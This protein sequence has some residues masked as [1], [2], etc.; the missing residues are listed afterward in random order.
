MRSA[1]R[2]ARWPALVRVVPM[3]RLNAV[4]V[5]ARSRAT[6]TTR[7]GSSPWSRGRGAQT[8]RSWHVYYLQNSH[9]NDVA[10]V[11]Q[12]AFTP[13]NVTAQPSARAT[14]AS[15]QPLRRHATACNSSGG[16]GGGSGGIG[17]G[18]RRRRR[19][20]HRRSAAAA[21]ARRQQ[22]G[23]A[24]GGRAPAARRQ[25]PANPLLGGLEP[26]GGGAGGGDTDTTMRIIPNPQNNAVLIYATPQEDD[27]VE[28][29]LRKIDILPLQVRIDAI[30]AEVTLN[31]ELQYGTQFFFKAAA[32]STASSTLSAAGSAANRRCVTAF[33]GFVLGG[34]GK[35]AHR[36]AISALQAVTTV[37]VLSSPRTAG[38]RQPAGPAAGRRAGAV[39]DAPARRAR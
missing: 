23:G 21:A 14:G 7:A 15:A 24:L 34:S 31:D 28:A 38:A 26:G 19:R 8:V 27:T 1:A 10:Y 37:H 5:V 6:S 35:A 16:S 11:L 30:I 22:P 17:G 39:P 20:R 29:M 32:A 4:L 36:C 12:Q 18:L 13:D 9:A 2:A 25:N 33:P 3:E